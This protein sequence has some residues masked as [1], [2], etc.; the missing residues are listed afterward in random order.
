MPSGTKGASLQTRDECDLFGAIPN[1]GLR[2]RNIYTIGLALDWILSL[3]F[4]I[5]GSLMTNAKNVKV[6]HQLEGIGIIINFYAH[7][8]PEE[9]FP[10]S[11]RIYHLIPGGNLL[12]TTLLNFLVTIVLDSTNYNHAVTLR[13]VLF[14]EGRLRF[15]SNIRLFTR[16]KCHGPNSW[17]FNIISGV[18]LAIS[19]GALSCMMMEVNVEGAVNKQKQV[20]EKIQSPPR[21]FVEVNLLAVSALG[22]GLLLQVVVSTY[23]LLCS[24]GV[25]TWSSN[26]LANAKA[27][28]GVQDS[29]SK[30]GSKFTPQRSQDSM[31]S[32]APEIRLIRYLIWGFCGLST[33][34]SLGQG[35]YVSV[36]GYM[37]DDKIAWFRKP[38]QYWKF[39]GAMWAPFGKISE[40]SSYWLGLLVQIVLQSFLTLALHCLE[41]L[42]NIP[43]DEATWRNMETVGSKPSP[44][45]MSNLSRQ[46]LFLSIIKATLHWIFG[47]AFSADLTFNIALMLIIALM[48][49]FIPLAVLTEYMIKKRPK[50]SIPGCY[51]NF[52][53]VWGWVDEWNHQKLFWGDK[54][55]LVLGF[56]RAGTSGKRLPELHSNILY[57][58][59]QASELERE[60]S[61]QQLKLG[62]VSDRDSTS[63]KNVE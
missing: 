59:S 8:Y 33:T 20:F 45:I 16:S 17:Y 13:W 43:R 47:Y 62:S 21:G 44:S 57:Y 22:I 4:I 55:E 12:V 15:D 56:R 26:L 7:T 60:G 11:H 6:P 3:I 41:L 23:S 1:P 9:P 54:G 27:I 29:R 53:R 35:V 48:V 19:H 28:A 49:V 51:G 38:M 63:D 58:C 32:I 36:C 14:R 37:T 18:G 2:T 61:L 10:K 40:P 42:F 25:L 46:G 30:V 24:H 34:W 50:G 31:L 52:Q 5:G 39:Y